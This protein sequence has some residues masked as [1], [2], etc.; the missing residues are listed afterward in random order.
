MAK[1]FTVTPATVNSKAQELHSQNARLKSLI[2]SMRAQE[3]SLNG[4]WDGEANDAFHNAFMKD[5]TQMS[6]FYNA[7]EQ[8][9]QKL[10]EIAKKYQ[11]AENTNCGIAGH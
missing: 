10:Q 3:E 4:M 9:V 8:Y 2:E 5:I 7:I 6:N 1:T 11:Q